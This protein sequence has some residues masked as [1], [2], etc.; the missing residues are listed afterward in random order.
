MIIDGFK[1][2]I[3]RSKK[4][5]KTI[6]A[7]LTGE[8]SIRVLAPYA[9]S[10]DFV[11]GFVKKTAEKFAFKDLISGKAGD[12]QKRAE[13]LKD[14]YMPKAPDFTISYSGSLKSAWGKCFVRDKKIILN[15]RLVSFPL[16]VTDY[17]IIHEIV[18]LIYPDHG[19]NFRTQVSKYRLKERAT[20][21][22]LAKGLTGSGL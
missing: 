11:L 17:V 9:A 18:H 21:Y 14:K 5:K 10:G 4:R 8:S 7:R 13:M 19:K 22:L 16:W 6:Q 1:I 20:G 2:E 3:I 12:L 15:P